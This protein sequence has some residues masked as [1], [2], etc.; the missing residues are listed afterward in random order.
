MKA[1]INTIPRVGAL[2]RPRDRD[3]EDFPIG[4]TVITPLGKKAV[5]LKHCYGEKRG[6][7]ARLLCRYLDVKNAQK[8]NVLLIPALVELENN[9]P[10]EGGKKGG[11]VE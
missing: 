5:V 1:A 3:P 10:T 4:S 7:Q 11:I 2:A 6:G 8:A 9:S